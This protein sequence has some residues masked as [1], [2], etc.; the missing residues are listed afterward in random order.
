MPT[1]YN[2]STRQPEQLDGA[3]LQIAL[4]QGTHAYELGQTVKL[5]DPKNPDSRYEVDSQNVMGAMKQ[6]F[7]VVTPSQQAV[8]DYVKQ[9]SG[10]IGGAKV[11]LGEMANQ[12]LLGIPGIIY[13]KKGDPLE[14]AK[15]EALRKEHGFADIL[16]GATGIGASLFTGAPLFKGAAEA[17]KAAEILAERLIAKSGGEIGK[18]TALEAARDIT[19]GIVAKGAGGAAEGLALTAPVAIT[20]AML[21]DHDQAAESLMAGVGIGSVL[22]VGGMAAKELFGL[23]KKVGEYALTGGKRALEGTQDTLETLARKTG[24]MFTGV[25][26]DEQLYYMKNSPR[27]EA[28]AEKYLPQVE[29][30]HNRILE[31]IQKEI[32]Q[33]VS[34]FSDKSA[35][36]KHAQD[37][38][39]QELDQ[40]YQAARYELAQKDAP[41]RVALDLLGHLENEKAVLGDLSK[42]ADQAL[43]DSGVTVK[44]E[45]LLNFVQKWID[46]L[47]PK[48]GDETVSAAKNLENLKSRM[49]AEL[50][51][52]VDAPVVRDVLQQVRADAYKSPLAA[53]EFNTT[54][55]GVK[56]NFARDISELL[57][58]GAPEYRDLMEQMATRSQTLAEMSKQFGT[59]EKA[60]SN[61][62]KIFS[63]GTAKLKN[64]LLEKFSAITGKDFIGELSEL[65]GAKEA[66]ERIKKGE[67]LRSELLPGLFQKHADAA[68]HAE[69]TANTF[70]E[71]KKLTPER[72]QSILKRLGTPS[73][74]NLDRAAIE[75]LGNLTGKN[76]LQDIDDVNNYRSFFKSDRNG[77]RKSTPGAVAG[78]AV[79]G[80]IGGPVGAAIGS[81]LGGVA[82]MAFDDYGGQLLKKYLRAISS[83]QA[84]DGI[85]FTEKMMKRTADKLD[86]IPEILKSMSEK[87]PATL[88]TSSISALSRL[89]TGKEHDKK[90][91]YRESVERRT[92]ELKGLSDKTGQWVSNPNQ[93]GQVLAHLSEG[94]KSGGAPGVAEIFNQKLTQGVQYLHE[95]MP[96]PPRPDTPFA[97]SVP[98]KPSDAELSRYEQRVAVVLDPFVVLTEMKHNTLTKTHI[99]T[100]KAVYPQTYNQIK[101]RVIKESMQGIKPISYNKRAKLSMLFETP[102]DPSQT[103]QAVWGYQ[104]AFM[105]QDPTVDPNNK[106]QVEIA[107][108][109][110]SDVQRLMG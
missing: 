49:S 70:A 74:S 75:N 10:A 54:L 104:K 95:N 47:G 100:L 44:K 33:H 79:G 81:S 90:E 62:S 19:S 106:K 8:D 96:K 32:D 93:V 78:A 57:K 50:G 83:P 77:S 89:A 102:L 18:R 26:E 35:L 55:A 12:A 98:W 56:K 59:K 103:P 40:S 34:D 24:K 45:D 16:G 67:D 69:Q 94:L 20:E 39:R 91:N 41:D 6:G 17:G 58:G 86:R 88:R 64:D 36:A 109:T 68:A 9:N 2:V 30:D 15:T 80:A 92:K 51:E 101:N 13:D 105:E 107:K 60:Y 42:Q 23:G 48:I 61:L 27:V 108:Q 22:G 71:V 53:G 65:K 29:G 37:S 85:L 25:P 72:T 46:Q 14:V 31:P 38:A 7:Q 52:V 43:G 63:G 87:T 110:Y 84:K 97:R 1:L 4:S 66:L 99:D 21:G 73:A 82:G 5:F 3:D 76:F 28:A 11:F